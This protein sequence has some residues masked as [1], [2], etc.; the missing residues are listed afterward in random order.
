MYYPYLR[1]RQFE[2][3]ALR[4]Y[5]LHHGE[6][7]NIIPIIEPVKNT[8]N[9]MKLALPKLIEGH[10]KFALILN[11]QVGEINN[12]L[13]ITDTLK[14]E[15]V[16]SSKWIP[17]F[18]VTNNYLAV[19][20]QIEESGYADIMLICSENTDS[21]DADFDKL[22]LLPSIKYIVSTENK[23]LKR[24]LK[25]FGKE[26]IRLDD[27][28]KAQK[29]NSDYLMMAEEKFSEEH[30]F[31]KEEG[32]AGFSDYTVLVSDYIEGGAA[33]YAVAIHL[34]YQKENKEI[35]IKHFT[36]ITNDDQ[37]N[38]QRKFAEA[39]EKTVAF[40]NSKNIHNFATEELRAYYNSRSYPGLGMVKKISIKNHLEL[41]NDVI[42]ID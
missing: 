17:T 35:W 5:A 9:S 28:F 29:R 41:M 10:V 27:N 23:T 19:T 18:I 34:T 38:I 7:N 1:G 40:L 4:E 39:A 14:E 30:L 16:D 2:L 11:P 22:A 20:S 21:C 15:L 3:I 26:L 37:S 13:E 42:K 31:Y 8:F 33:P 36:S 12:P 25:N 32:Y 6:N 24:K